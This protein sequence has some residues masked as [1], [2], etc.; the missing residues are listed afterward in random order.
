MTVS[1]IM[2][3]VNIDSTLYVRYHPKVDN[4]SIDNEEGY[5]PWGHSPSFCCWIIPKM[6]HSRYGP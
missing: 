2:H 1:K 6:R 3:H 5:D 4:I